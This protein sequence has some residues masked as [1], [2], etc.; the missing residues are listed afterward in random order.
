MMTP[1]TTNLEICVRK[2][3]NSYGPGVPASIFTLPSVMIQLYVL[4]NLWELHKLLKSSSR[5]ETVDTKRSVSFLFSLASN[6]RKK[7]RNDTYVWFTLS[8]HLCS[9]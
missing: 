3:N 2:S 5:L 6:I 8:T 9:M 1:L 7:K 4:M